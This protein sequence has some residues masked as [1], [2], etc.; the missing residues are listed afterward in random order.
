MGVF[1]KVSFSTSKPFASLRYWWNESAPGGTI[2][3]ILVALFLPSSQPAENTGLVAHLK[4]KFT[5][6]AFAR[7]DVLGTIFLLAFSVL[8]VFALEEAGSRYHWS[9]PVII[10]TIVFS[11]VAGVGFVSWEWWIERAKG[12]QEPTFPLSLLKES[13]LASMIA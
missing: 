12:K 3:L 8:L 7:L 11:A 9:S 10:V 13:V 6:A 1:V 2:S 4:G 5:R